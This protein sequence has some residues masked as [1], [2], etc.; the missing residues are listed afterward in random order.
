MVGP[1][2]AENEDLPV[3]QPTTMQTDEEANNG[4]PVSNNELQQY[5]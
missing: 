4:A 3:E 1:T 5:L 2:V